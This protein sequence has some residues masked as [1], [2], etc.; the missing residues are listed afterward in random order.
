VH[1]AAAKPR[2]ARRVLEVRQCGAAR[3][4]RKRVR[5]AGRAMGCDLDFLPVS[6][7]R[8]RLHCHAA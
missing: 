4:A 7:G 3:L 6:S 8:K 2:V 5:V 1:P